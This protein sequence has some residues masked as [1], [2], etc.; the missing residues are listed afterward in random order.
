MTAVSAAQHIDVL[1]VIGAG[2]AGRPNNLLPFSVDMLGLCR[3][4]RSAPD[5]LL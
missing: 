3:P 2:F 5:G 4:T 1:T